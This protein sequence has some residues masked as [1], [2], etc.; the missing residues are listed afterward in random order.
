MKNQINFKNLDDEDLTVI[1]NYLQ[2]KD[3]RLHTE[4]FNSYAVD[5]VENKQ[6]AY[7]IAYSMQCIEMSILYNLFIDNKN[8]IEFWINILFMKPD[9]KFLLERAIKNE[10]TKRIH[11]VY[12]NKFPENNTDLIDKINKI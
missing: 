4:F 9:F 8:Y 5:S 1:S 2:E 3:T 6:L 12:L 11:E 10:K 7:Q